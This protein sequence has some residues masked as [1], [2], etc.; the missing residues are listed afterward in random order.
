MSLSL[1]TR[2]RRALR[3][4]V[5]VILLSSYVTGAAVM[6]DRA[7]LLREPEFSGCTARDSWF[8][9]GG[10]KFVIKGVGWD[11]TRPGEYPWDGVRTLELVR[12]DFARIR[13]A[14]FNTLRTWESLTPDELEIAEAND[15]RVLQGIWIDPRGDFADP[16]FREEQLSKIRRV[17][18]FSSKSSA[19]LGY[20]VMN[21]PDPAHLI[22]TGLETSR[23]FLREITETAHAVDPNAL[24]SYSSWPGLEFFD[25]PELDFVAVNLYPVRPRALMDAIG[26]DGMVQLWKESHASQRPLVVTEFGVSVAP[27]ERR[28]NRPGGWSEEEQAVVLPELADSLMR[29]GAAGGVAFMWI[30]GWWKNDDG[31]GDE[32]SR[33]PSDAE[34]W[35]GLVAMETEGDHD[36]R[37]RPVL[38]ALQRWNRAVLTSPECGTR[39]SGGCEIGIYIEEEVRDLRLYASVDGGREERISARQEGRWLRARLDLAPSSRLVKLSLRSKGEQLASWVRV[40]DEASPGLSLDLQVER[41]NGATFAVARVLDRNRKGVSEIAVHMAISEARHRVDHFAVVATDESGVA[42]LPIELPPDDAP[43]VV[44][45]ALRKNSEAP[46]SVLRTLVVGGGAAL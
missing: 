25:V 2:R 1:P 6:L 11:P 34:E 13:A 46:P 15:L 44:V 42:R 29:S 17:V 3:L 4:S 33:D 7:D 43:G 21:E 31:L 45:A 30:D 35:F 38:A 5:L 9:C 40:I 14:G 16:L 28:D 10:E 8:Y 26:Y 23:Q 24:V 27:I 12:A 37:P 41:V 19:I 22:S 39:T 18:E 32:K 36:G 20:L